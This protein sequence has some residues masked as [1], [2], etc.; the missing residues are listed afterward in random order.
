MGRPKTVLLGSFSEI[1]RDEILKLRTM[2]P[3]WG[4]LTIW[5]ELTQNKRFNALKIPKPSSIARY[6]R[7]KGLTKK[8]ERH[9]E[10]PRSKWLQAKEAHEL[11]QIDAQGATDIPDLG[12]VNFINIKDG[13]SKIYCGSMPLPARSHNGSPSASDYQFCLRLAFCEFGL[14]QKIQA[15]HAAVFYENKGKSPFP[16]M[17]HLWLLSLGINL[18]FSRKYRPTDQSGVERMHQTMEHQIKRKAG[19]H[20]FEQLIK[21]ANQR[22]RRL[23]QDIPCRSINKLPPLVAFPKAIHSGRSY[24][25]EIEKQLMNLDNVFQFLHKGKWYR[26]IS[27]VKK[28]SIGGQKYYVKNATPLSTVEVSFNYNHQSLVFRNVKEQQILGEQP[29]KGIDKH[30]LL[31]NGFF[32]TPLNG[33]QLQFP[34]DFNAQKLSTTF[35][36]N[37]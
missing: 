15:D 33:F 2:H 30:S 37:T 31:G 16:T 35:L 25:P 1:I 22:R 23:N 10:L 14:P 24:R 9:V 13:Y 18:V 5:I 8:Y 32:E 21:F 11:W 19:F 6:L 29:I 7:L 17:F 36:D 3:A 20:S 27:K 28:T 12:R 34:F 4:P 26:K